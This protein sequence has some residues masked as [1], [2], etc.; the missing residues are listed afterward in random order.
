MV[1]TGTEVLEERVES[2]RSQSSLDHRRSEVTNSVSQSLAA[3]DS[4]EE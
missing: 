3:I 1:N 2:F 4:E